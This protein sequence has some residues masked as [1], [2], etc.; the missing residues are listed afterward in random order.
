MPTLD[1]ARQDAVALKGSLIKAGFPA[2]NIMLMTDTA[3]GPMY[4]TRGNLRARINNIA[5]IVDKEDVLLMFFSGHGTQKLGQGYLVPIDGSSNDTS[6][7]VS[8]KWVK[9]TLETSSAKHRLLILD[10]CH[11]G[12]KAGDA[13]NSPAKTML[14]NLSGAAFATL[15]SCDASQLSYEDKARGHGVFTSAIID[16][17][18]GAAD[19]MAQGNNDNIVTATELWAYAALKTKQWSVRTGKIQTPVLRGNFKGRLQVFK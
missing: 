11:S 12:A 2:D 9:T 18:T 14:S 8:L 13:A 17:L 1:F 7:L 16:G 6:S 15:S 3:T 4:P 10:A 19:I 5:T